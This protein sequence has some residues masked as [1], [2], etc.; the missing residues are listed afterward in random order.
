MKCMHSDRVRAGMAAVH[1]RRCWLSYAADCL[2]YY[3]QGNMRAIGIP[4]QEVMEYT[5]NR[6]QQGENEGT[7]PDVQKY[8]TD[9]YNLDDLTSLR[10]LTTRIEELKTEKQ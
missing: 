3:N 2:R 8:Y 4:E 6:E 1:N 10:H 5:D 9:P 7:P